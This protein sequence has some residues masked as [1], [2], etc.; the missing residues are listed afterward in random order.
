[1]C[2]VEFQEK[3]RKQ[4]I[5]AVYPIN[6]GTPTRPRYQKKWTF[7]N[8]MKAT[9]AAEPMTKMLPPVPAQ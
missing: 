8:P 2:E 5:P 7:S 3:R 6:A 4:P 1:M 9:P